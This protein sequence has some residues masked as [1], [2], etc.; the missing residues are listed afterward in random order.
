M[1]YGACGD[2]V[3]QDQKHATGGEFANGFIAAEYA[4]G[5]E[6]DLTVTITAHHKGYFKFFLCDKAEES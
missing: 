1:G 6:I 5:S 2:N 4:P 3:S